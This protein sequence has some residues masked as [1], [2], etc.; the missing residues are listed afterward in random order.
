FG[1]GCGRIMRWMEPLAGRCELS[2]TDIDERAISWATEN[3]PFARWGVNDGLPPTSYGDGE[4]DLILNHSVF[5]HLD[6]RYQDAW[7][8]ELQR[9]AAPDG[10]LVLSVHGQ[11]AFDVSE[12][13][14]ERDS[15]YRK[16]WRETL[17][18][19]GILFV[20][21]DSYVGS[22]FPDFYH[23]TFHAP[24]YLFEHWTRWFDVLAYPPRSSLGFQDQLVLRRRRPEEEALVPL[25]ARPVSAPAPSAA[26][27][28]K[29]PRRFGA[30][31]LLARRAVLRI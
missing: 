13:M 22:A 29:P 28:A 26:S 12:A 8:G 11:H 3:L 6:E 1:C 27:A 7:L 30:P 14:L 15:R 16:E 31:G 2:G 19:D 23:T 9:I 4:F 18:R 17:E 10:L 5:T 20:A 24:W 21:E 25:R